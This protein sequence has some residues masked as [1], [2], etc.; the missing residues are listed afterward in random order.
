L[1][2]VPNSRRRIGIERVLLEQVWRGELIAMYAMR[3]ARGGWYAVETGAGLHAPVFRSRGDA[4]RARI[5][6]WRMLFCKPVRL[7]ERVVIALATREGETRV[8]FWLVD[9]PW[10]GLESGRVLNHGQLARLIY[11]VKEQDSSVGGGAG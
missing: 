4:N 6:N 11:G 3:R 9:D 2:A 10:A 7:D 8:D 5:R 1:K